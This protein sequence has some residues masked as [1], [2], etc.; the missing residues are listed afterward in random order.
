VRLEAAEKL[1]SISQR[2]KKHI[3][4]AL[5]TYDWIAKPIPKLHPAFGQIAKEFVQRNTKNAVY[6][7]GSV[8]KSWCFIET[9]GDSFAQCSIGYARVSTSEQETALQV[10][11]LKAAKCERI[12]SR[13]SVW[14]P[15]GQARPNCSGFRISSVRAMC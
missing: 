7:G 10:A 5:Y 3:E 6:A 11:A 12:L 13:A 14:R 4:K 1:A 2:D 15:L 8:A 9:I